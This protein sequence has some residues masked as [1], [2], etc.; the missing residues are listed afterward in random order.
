MTNPA[1]PRL[2]ARR[3]HLVRMAANGHT[4]AAIADLLGISINTV[5]AEIRSA[6]RALG[7]RDRAHAVAIAM[8]RGL[9]HPHEIDLPQ[10][11]DPKETA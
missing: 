10:S 1:V 2:T 11:T 5:S 3:L 4:N 9:I 6:Q 7:A 8:T